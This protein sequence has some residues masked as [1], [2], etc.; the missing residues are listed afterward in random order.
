MEQKINYNKK[1]MPVTKYAS[2]NA[3]YIE[4]Y[5]MY[6]IDGIYLKYYDLCEIASV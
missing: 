4:I 2:R 3:W 6:M 5:R 1:N